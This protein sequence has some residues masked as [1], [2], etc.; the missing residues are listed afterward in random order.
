M[1]LCSALLSPGL[2]ASSPP[3]SEAIYSPL[4]PQSPEIA[5]WKPDVCN[6]T[7][8][9]NREQAT[10]YAIYLGNYAHLYVRWSACLLSWICLFGCCGSSSYLLTWVVDRFVL[11]SWPWRSRRLGQSCTPRWVRQN[12]VLRS[13]ISALWV[14]EWVQV[15]WHQ[16]RIAS[17]TLLTR[18]CCCSECLY[19]SQSPSSPPT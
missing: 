13:S 16:R 3:P 5:L 18:P 1:G 7:R 6:A 4:P 9:W 14:R 17:W 15:F 10:K 19:P 2:Q 12:W 11:S 8:T